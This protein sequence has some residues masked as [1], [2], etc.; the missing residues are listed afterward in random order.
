MGS[1][2]A[3]ICVDKLGRAL[4][5]SSEAYVRGKPGVLI[6]GLNG[7]LISLLPINLDSTLYFVKN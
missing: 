2:W 7:P 6:Y 3:G 5:L 1:I 4:T